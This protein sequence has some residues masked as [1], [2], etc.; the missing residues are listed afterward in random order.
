MNLAL[1]L[2]QMKKMEV[3]PPKKDMTYEQATNPMNKLYMRELKK[4]MNPPDESVPVVSSLDKSMSFVPAGEH[5][6]S[7]IEQMATLKF[8]YKNQ[9]KLNKLKNE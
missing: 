3:V 1:N 8:D 4:E 2:K 9:Y 6:K 5:A 7:Q